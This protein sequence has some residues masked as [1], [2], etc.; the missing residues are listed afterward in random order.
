[1]SIE[2]GKLNGAILADQIRNMDWH[3]RKVAFIQKAPLIAVT[4]VQEHI[5]RLITEE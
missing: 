5:V 1:M 3:A 4:I 2:A